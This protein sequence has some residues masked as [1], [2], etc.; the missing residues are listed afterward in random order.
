MIEQRVERLDR[1]FG[2]RFDINYAAKAN[3]NKAVL[4]L[5]REAGIGLDVSSIGEFQLG[6]EAGFAPAQIGF[7]G[8][9]KRRRELEV[10]SPE[11]DD[12]APVL[13]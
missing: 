13:A 1:A 11:L 12:D 5:L 3:P 6:I 10:P 8:P 4:S 2:E 9:G 7:T